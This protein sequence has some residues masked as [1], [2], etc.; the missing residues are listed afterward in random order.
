MLSRAKI[1]LNIHSYDAK[2]SFNFLRLTNAISERALVISEIINMSTPFINYKH[3]I[4]EDKKDLPE[5]CDVY[6]KE[7]YNE[8]RLLA[9]DAFEFMK[10]HYAMKDILYNFIVEKIDNNLLNINQKVEIPQIQ[11]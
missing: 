1:A 11:G 2:T 3:I 7:K 5:V 8:G 6:L 9:D 10:N 4:L